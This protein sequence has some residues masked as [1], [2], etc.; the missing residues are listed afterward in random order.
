MTDWCDLK[1]NQ[2]WLASDVSSVK[3]TL[4]KRC[5]FT[6]ACTEFTLFCILVHSC[7]GFLIRRNT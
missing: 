6:T 1:Q 3:Q 7:D 2:H 4:I 5:K